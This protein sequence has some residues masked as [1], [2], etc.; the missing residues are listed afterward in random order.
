MQNY[1]GAELQAEL[2]TILPSTYQFLAE[3]LQEPLPAILCGTL[4][5]L[6]Q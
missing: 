3:I 4:Q 1:Q 2:L 5:W 6:H